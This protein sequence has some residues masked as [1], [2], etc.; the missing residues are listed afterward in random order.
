MNLAAEWCVL[1]NSPKAAKSEADLHESL[2]RRYSFRQSA[3]YRLLRPPLPLVYNKHERHLPDGNGLALLVG[4]AGERVPAGFINVDLVEFPGV[5]VVADI[6]ALPFAAQSI[7]RVECNAVLEHV[8]D[9]RA[10]V[11]EL[12]R[13][14]KPGGYAHF[15]V[16]F[17]HPLHLYPSDYRRWTKEGL[18][19][20]LGA[21]DIVDVGVRSGP[22]ATLLTFFLE[23]L[24]LLSPRVCGK[25]VFAGAGWLLWPLRYLDLLLL[26]RADADVLANHIYALVQKPTSEKSAPDEIPR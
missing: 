10:A 14:L 19:K 9:A 22:T 7:S 4:G 20:L 15:V 1:Q 26:R 12:L 5:D 6:E 16:P 23:Y 11:E 17:C 8:S 13:V 3:V 18:C 25:A 2:R 24:K 21:F